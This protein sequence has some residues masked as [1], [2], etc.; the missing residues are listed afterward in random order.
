MMYKPWI[1]EICLRITQRDDSPWPDVNFEGLSHGAD[2]DFLGDFRMI[3]KETYH[4]A[5]FYQRRFADV[6]IS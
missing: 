4:R 3:E 5:R 6:N 2:L 1:I